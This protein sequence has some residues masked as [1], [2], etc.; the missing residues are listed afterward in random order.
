M[1]PLHMKSQKAHAGPSDRKISATESSCPLSFSH[2]LSS[3]SE[4]LT[5]TS[6]SVPEQA[7]R[8]SEEL[9]QLVT[10]RAPLMIWMSGV[11]KLC[12]YLN[13]NWLRFRGRSLEQEL[14]EGWAEGLH[15][16]D[17]TRVMELYV[18]AFDRREELKVEY[19][20]RR[21][22]GEYRWILDHS[23][24]RHNLDGTF[25]GY[26]GFCIDVTEN[27]KYEQTLSTL[28]QRLIEAHEEER[29]F[30]A[31]ELHDN[32]NQ[33]VALLGVQLD[34]LARKPP[35]SCADLTHA[36]AQ[37]ARLGRKISSEIQALCHRLHPSKLR[38]LGLEAAAKSFCKEVS[39]R[40]EV[41]VNFHAA[42]VPRDLSP[43]VSLCLFRVLQESVQ[44]V[45]KHSGSHE[46]QVRLDA[47]SEIIEV[48]VRDSGIGFSPDD[49]I[50]G[51]GLGLTSMNERMKLI[52]GML[53]IESK[54]KHGTI[55]RATAPISRKDSD[56]A[57][58]AAAGRT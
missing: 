7:L 19:R 28:S 36:L 1:R 31:R 49:L 32:V 12:T 37:T 5:V 55:V 52:D 50:V 14:G 48:Q 23:A 42:S 30:I 33:Q 46:I 18:D 57:K 43:E 3:E 22:D 38:V 40:G 54:P 15:P 20:L 56:S 27:K 39:D 58:H 34:T 45:I 11:D 29:A 4:P 51:T 6:K 24:P 10:N 35:T 17:T 13:L 41:V 44:N 53:S 47:T 16:D 26:L 9:F 8:E 21:H 25:A 2:P